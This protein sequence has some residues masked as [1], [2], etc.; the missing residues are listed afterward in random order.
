VGY[1]VAESLGFRR[2]RAESVLA[3][4]ALR[5]PDEIV[6]QADVLLA[7]HWRLRQYK[8]RPERIDF[9]RVAGRMFFGVV[10]LRGLRLLEGDL[11]VSRQ[12]LF[13]ASEDTWRNTLSIAVERQQAANW[14]LGEEP[15][16]SQVTCDT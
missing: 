1:R 15:V 13:E 16:Y 8:L 5:D 11:E 10:P 4:P 14:L 6:H 3:S 7:L 9:R 12:L 2:P